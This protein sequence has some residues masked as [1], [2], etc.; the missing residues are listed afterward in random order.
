ML[1]SLQVT[2]KIVDFRIISKLHFVQGAHCGFTVITLTIKC[3][4]KQFNVNVIIF[5]LGLKIPGKALEKTVKHPSKS[6]DFL[7]SEDVQTLTVTHLAF[8]CSS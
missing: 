4:F 6:L 1:I 5:I 7:I 8:Y 3:C 2:I